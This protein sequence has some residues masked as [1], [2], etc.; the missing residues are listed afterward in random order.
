MTSDDGVSAMSTGPEAQRKR[1][2]YAEAAG[3][4]A[5]AATRCSPA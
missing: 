2:S 1:V 4:L 5:D 3:I